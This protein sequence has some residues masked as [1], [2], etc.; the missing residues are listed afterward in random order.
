MFAVIKTGGKQY[1]VKEGDVLSIEKVE[2]APGEAVTFDQVLLIE[3]EDRVLVGSPYLER[4]A[5]TGEVIETYKDDKVTVF[6]K[7]RRKGYRRTKGHRQMLT[8][9]KIDGIYPEWSGH[10]ERKPVEEE[11]QKPV[12]KAA[13]T[14]ARKATSPE[15]AEAEKTPTKK[16]PRTAKKVQNK[17]ESKEN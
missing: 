11:A 17:E 12:E 15:V 3:A 14:R 6:K 16:T 7:K 9:V 4:A 13:R 2:A 1:R 8:K 5:V 10:V